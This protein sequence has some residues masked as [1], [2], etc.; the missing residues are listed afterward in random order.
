MKEIRTLVGVTLAQLNALFLAVEDVV[1]LKEAEEATLPDGKLCGF[2]FKQRGDCNFSL[3]IKKA[4]LQKG[5]TAL[6]VVQL[7][8]EGKFQIEVWHGDSLE[9][10]ELAH[11]SV[12][13]TGNWRNK[14]EWEALGSPRLNYGVLH[15]YPAVSS[16]I[17]RALGFTETVQQLQVVPEVSRALS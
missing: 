14:K 5:D 4:Q 2:M 1:K 7:G 9:K 6:F 15:A 17:D 13:A 10:V 12:T 3:Y 16:R 8:V 11:Q